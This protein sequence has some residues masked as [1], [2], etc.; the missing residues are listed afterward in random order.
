MKQRSLQNKITRMLVW[1]A[2]ACFMVGA[3]VCGMIKYQEIR[4]HYAA[5]MQA[6]I[7]VARSFVKDI[8]SH[9]DA[10]VKQT[11]AQLSDVPPSKLPII[12]ADTIF[13]NHPGETF[14]ILDRT[15]TVLSIPEPFSDYVGLD[16][17]GMVAADGSE[18]RVQHQQSLLSKHSVIT[19][20]YPLADGMSLILERNL[21]N[22]IPVMAHFEKGSHFDEE[23]F[24]VLSDNG[25]V[26]Y[27]PDSQLVTSRYNLGF[28]L[29][30]QSIPDTD[31]LFTLM[32]QKQKYIALS[33]RFSEP[34]CWTIFYC[35]PKSEIITTVVKTILLQFF[36]L[37]SL[38]SLLVIVLRFFLNRFFSQPI[39]KIV[40]LLDLSSTNGNL[41]ISQDIA[42]GTKE[43]QTIIE[44]INSRD[45]KRQQA[46]AKEENA[47]ALLKSLIDSI[48][49][50]I[51]YKNRESVYL[52]CNKAFCQFT[53]RSEKTII[54]HTDLDMFPREVAE[55][56]R[57][58]D[59]LMFDK[60]HASRNEEWVDYPDGS[61]VLLD[62]LKTPF[63]GPNGDMLGIIGISRDITEQRHTTEEKEKLQLQLQQVQKM[64]AIGTLAGGIAH[65]FNNI[66]SSVLGY[67]ELAMD[68]VEK[69]SPLFKQLEQIFQAG[70]RA[71]DL[72]KQI[73][74]FS[75]QNKMDRQP[76]K[77]HLI[78]KEALK[79][80]RSSIPATI[81]IRQDIDPHSG[82]LL[83]NPTQVHQILMN[84]C[85]NAYHAMRRHGGVLSVALEPLEIAENDEKVRN[86]LLAP[87][88][89]LKLTVSDTGHGMDRATC[90]RIF[91]PYFT[92]KEEGE[93]SGMGLAVV[94]GIVKDYN[95]HIDVYSEPDQGTT[96]HIYLP[97]LVDRLAYEESKP[98]TLSPKGHERIL[99]VDDEKAI[100]EME[101]VMLEI[102]GY[103][104]TSFT[105]SNEA[106]S[107]FV[108]HPGNFD[109]IITDM[110]M[111]QM[112]GS[113][114]TRKILA[115]RPDMPII[116][117][118]GFSELINEKKAK[119]LGIRE[120][121]LKPVI[122]KDI[123]QIIRKV[124]DGP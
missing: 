21:E 102:L 116:L 48:P 114:L 38:F 2:L 7:A 77:I 81:E 11:I 42:E 25:R 39:E 90:Q 14:Y 8:V 53:G 61:K 36:L 44:A 89:Y 93:G 85:T 20:Q 95:G 91:D 10:Y 70:I 16:F 46:E 62:T 28:D 51:F 107:F 32:Y 17:S 19:I 18:R 105:D 118:T 41:P 76:V 34:D 73:L 69:D 50:L 98:S 110:T 79:L 75:R 115:V 104:V 40:A 26:V 56:F 68:E 82:T 33:D 108:Q 100:V 66:L 29:Q 5:I 23:L 1:V 94:H 55:F 99:L 60:G 88:P 35:V 84:L 43:L 4:E 30:R 31:K 57:S 13:F 74:T 103:R 15:G 37:V 96:F 83:A 59:R 120:Y 117:C 67:T 65:D 80:L 6:R 72:V 124:L 122:K 78:I 101:K 45:L 112:T 92:T 22:I 86:L 119:E 47:Y 121:I 54:H 49:D 109:L 71:K 52:G 24:F 63:Y 12:L 64:E 9:D 58:K 106:Y 113:E 97:R 87:G 111:P 27:H 123:A 3:A